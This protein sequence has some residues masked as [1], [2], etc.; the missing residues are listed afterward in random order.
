MLLGKTRRRADQLAKNPHYTYRPES[1][2]FSVL[3]PGLNS[4]GGFLDYENFEARVFDTVRKKL[5]LMKLNF[6][7]LRRT[8]ATLAVG[9]RRGT[10]RDV[11]QVLRH[12]RPTLAWRT[13]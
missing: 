10:V 8:F 5:G 2:A 1:W 12:T 13:L 3:M 6:Q 7:I 4:Q 11:Q 9:E